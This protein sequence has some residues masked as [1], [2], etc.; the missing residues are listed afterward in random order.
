MTAAAE[1]PGAAERDAAIDQVREAAEA[2][3]YTAAL[4]VVCELATRAP[5]LTTDD[6]WAAMQQLTATAHEPRVL[7][8]I[9]RDAAQY[10]WIAATDQF[11]ASTRPACHRRPLR[12]WNSNLYGMIKEKI[13]KDWTTMPWIAIDTETTGLDLTTT[14]I[15]ELAIVRRE[16]DGKVSGES[17]W[18]NP[19]IPIPDELIRKFHRTQAQLAEI[20]AA[21]PFQIA[22]WWLQSALEPVLA[23]E[24]LLIAYNGDAYDLPLITEEAK[25]IGS[26]FKRPAYTAD[27]LT[28]VR[29][30]RPNLP[31]KNLGAACA[32]F[33]VAPGT[34]HR[35]EDDCRATIGVLEKLAPELPHDLDA[36][37]ASTLSAGARHQSDSRRFGYM[38][39]SYSDT[40]EHR[41]RLIINYG[42]KMG[43]P[44]DK[45]PLWWIDEAL[46]NPKCTEETRRAL[47]SARLRAPRS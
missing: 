39:R 40:R 17:M 6:V 37:T 28:L 18:I 35:A 16:P 26:D 27:V 34:A 22:Y 5:T 43:C 11:V 32:H 36:I 42:S 41:E 13:V 33:N 45:A 23:G 44:L 24:A 10:A 30:F 20:Y 31:K 9:M 21:P 47:Q 4:A 12:V 2:D 15:Y 29:A 19:V 3:F 8:A 1:L 25:R 46:N 7:G 14:K 38:L